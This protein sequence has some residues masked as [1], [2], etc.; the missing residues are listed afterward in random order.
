VT[1][2][3]SSLTQSLS[4]LTEPETRDVFILDYHEKGKGTMKN[5]SRCSLDLNI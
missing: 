1:T 4:V 3:C 2:A 5:A